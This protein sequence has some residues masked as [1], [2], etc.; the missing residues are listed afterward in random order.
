MQFKKTEELKTGMRL[1]RP[2]Y[3]KNGVLLYE[4]A[5]KL[6]EQGIASIKNFGLI[7]IFILEP[8]EPVPPMSADDIEFERFQTV[9][10]F[11]IKEEMER[12][13]GTG[14]TARLQMIVS[15]IIKNY[16]HLEKKINFIQNLRSVEDYHHKHALNV[17]ILCAM[18]SNQMNLKVE[19][20]LD[21]VTAALLHG[22]GD[23]E[24]IDK[25]C[26]SNP[27]VKRY[28]MQ[29]DK[30]IES[31]EAGQVDASIK[32][33]DGSSIL[34]VAQ[35]Y[36]NMTA[37]GLEKPPETEVTAVRFLMDR[38]K[39]YS[40]AVVNALINS[41]NILGPG[42]CVELNTDEK[43]LVLAE[44]AGNIFRP[45][46]LCFGDNSIMDLGNQSA[47]GD[48]EIADIMKTMDNRHVMDTDMLKKYGFGE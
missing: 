4:R 19:E 8:A 1:A 42:V 24:R 6:T 46:I 5:S 45:I 47:Y 36:D 17:A 30:I 13:A 25:L 34:A 40:P 7:G 37:M 26:S 16:G 23:Y 18:M 43:A 39:V 35:V 41:I 48:V 22:I 11:A 21:V 9:N 20:R 15:N 32:L 38:D 2:I 27:N 28:C 44:N 33:M 10:V 14:R 29:A 31:E 3:N 12:I